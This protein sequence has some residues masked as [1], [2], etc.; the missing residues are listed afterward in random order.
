MDNIIILTIN[1]Q[2]GERLKQELLS[3]TDEF[4]QVGCYTKEE[5]L[6]NRILSSKVEHIFST[7]D[8]PQFEECEINEIFPSLKN[9]FYAAG[10]VKYFAKPFINNGINIYSAAKANCVPVAEFTV[11]QIILANKGYFQAQKSYKW[12]IGNYSFKKAR[13]IAENHTGNFDTT[14]GI[15]GCGAIG[16]MVVKL[17]KEY[18]LN[19]MVHDPYLSNQRVSEL[20]VKVASLSELFTNSDVISNHLPDISSTEGIINYDLLKQMK[21][22]ATLINTGRGRQIIE[23]D[24][25]KILR[26]RKDLTALL[27]VTSHEPL[28][29]WSPLYWC[30]NLFKTP[31][32]AGSLSNERHRMAEYMYIAY[33]DVLN[34]KDNECLISIKDFLNK[35]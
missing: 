23:K 24:L 9:I 13:K 33:N 32:I 25:F 15:I 3:I 7:W 22:N 19:V 29:P 11:A 4:D 30:K 28:Y 10:T 8:M 21:K 5:I 2:A 1:K 31:H 14:I 26:Q 16:S 18:K 35:A 27:D 17:L 34:G 12:C 20:G 6:G